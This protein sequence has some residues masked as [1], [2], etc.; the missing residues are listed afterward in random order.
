MSLATLLSFLFVVPVA[1]MLAFIFAH[2]QCRA[3]TRNTF[4]EAIRQPIFVVLILVGALMIILN[5]FLAAYS[6]D[7]GSGDNA[8]L[9]DLDLSTL[10]IVGVILAAF[11]ATGVV[12]SEMESHTALTVVSKPV[13]R[14]VF[15]LGKFAGVCGAIAVAIY[16]LTLVVLFTIRHKVM[17]N[18]S[19]QL[20]GP[21][22]I[23]GGGGALAAL[24]LAAAANYLYKRVFTSTFTILLAAVLTLALLLIMVIAPQWTFQSPLHDWLDHDSQ[25][26]QIA[27]GSA[28]IAQGVFIITALAVACSTRM[29]QVMT[30]MACLIVLV[31]GLTV[32]RIANDVNAAL[33]I[34]QNASTFQSISIIAGS[35]ETFVRKALF[36]L[37]KLL[38]LAAPNFQFHSPS[39]AISK[40]SSLVHDADGNFSLSYL[41]LVSTYTTCYTAALLGLGV[42]LFQK[43]EV[44]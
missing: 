23:L 7:P 14:A 3:I 11:T 43:R 34:T 24:F 44:S 39:E 29:S 17:Q 30:L 27:I 31:L 15:I 1:A 10:F 32:G 40:G 36:I 26:L 28:L 16:I 5:P 6:M 20:D 21:V 18:A 37:G 22:I 41:A 2:G 19:D 8:M 4:L 12:A 33:G 9:V 25:M 35:E 42:A 38:Y 13:P